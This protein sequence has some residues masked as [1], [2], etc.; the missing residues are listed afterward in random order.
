MI[1]DGFANQSAIVFSRMMVE[2]TLTTCDSL[3]LFLEWC[4]HH[5]MFIVF[6]RTADVSAHFPFCMIKDICTQRM[7]LVIS[8]ALMVELT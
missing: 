3:F 1:L 7:Y 5:S 6:N 8:T 4:P 2:R